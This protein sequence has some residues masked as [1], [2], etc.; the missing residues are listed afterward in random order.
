MKLAAIAFTARGL[1]LGEG[2]IGRLEPL[3]V[4]MSLCAGFGER[5]CSAAQ[6]TEQAFARRTPCCTWGPRGSPSAALRL[7]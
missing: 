7:F 1:R 3:G 4:Q 6:W 5:S 2:L